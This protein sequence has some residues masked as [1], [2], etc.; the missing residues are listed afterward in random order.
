MEINYLSK[1]VDPG[2]EHCD[3]HGAMSSTIGVREREREDWD[4]SN[5]FAALRAIRMIVSLVGC[6]KRRTAGN[7]AMRNSC[8][9]E[10]VDEQRTHWGRPLRNVISV[11]A[12]TR[13]VSESKRACVYMHVS[14]RM[15]L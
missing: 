8:A 10:H 13:R 15:F 5:S 11:S 14:R 2:V 9:L 3:I 4:S 12:C 1:G 6:G 7:K